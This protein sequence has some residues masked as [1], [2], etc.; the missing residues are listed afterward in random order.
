MLFSIYFVVFGLAFCWAGAIVTLAPLYGSQAL[1]L[2][3]AAIGRAL[4]I[5][6][7][8]EA[9]L[10]IPVGWAA[11]T[12]GR[13]RVLLP[14]MAVLVAG[15]VLLPLAGGLAGYTVACGLVIAGMTVWMI[16]ASLLAE[17]LLGRFGSRQVGIYRFVTDLGMVFA[18][19]I[20]GGLME[21]GGFGVGAG[22]LA[23]VVVASGGVAGLVLGPGR[24][25]PRRRAA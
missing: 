3:A 9:V 25:R 15:V 22:V 23:V 18:P 8:V 4:A 13:L 24:R 10:L 14:G 5:G 16:P 7:L 1:G 20:V 11:D 6:Y 2:S 17:Y 12:L 19:V 21:R